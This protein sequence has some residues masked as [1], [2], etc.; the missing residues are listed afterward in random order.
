MGIK[1]YVT[2]ILTNLD[3][4]SD[5]FVTPPP[6][7]TEQQ[8]VQAAEEFLARVVP[9]KTDQLRRDVNNYN[10]ESKSFWKSDG[11]RPFYGFHFSRLVNGIPFADNGANITVNGEGKVTSYWLNWETLKYPATENII[12][13]REA[14]DLMATRMGFDLGYAKISN[15]RGEWQTRLVYRVNFDSGQYVDAKSGEIKGRWSGPAVLSKPVFVDV[16]GHWAETD[17]KKLADQKI[18]DTAVNRFKPDEV[19][20]KGETISMLV[21]ALDLNRYFPDKPSFSD[22]TKE[23][24]YYG[25][26][27][28]AFKSGII[29]GDNGKFNPG[30]ELT[31][32]TL[33]V[34]AAKGFGDSKNHDDV[35]LDRFKDAGKISD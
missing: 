17:I 25:D 31:R 2:I 22:V 7:V 34:Y 8:A 18:I 21:K 23:Y 6:K 32:E 14:A 3:T 15:E 33:A 5:P 13:A 9:K 27:E 29:K 1:N 20:S 19:I 11:N 24:R 16:K 28:G 35:T 4:S 26:I 12:S 10:L 30:G